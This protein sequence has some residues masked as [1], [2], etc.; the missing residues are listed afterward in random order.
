VDRLRQVLA[1]SPTPEIQIRAHLSLAEVLHERLGDEDRALASLERVLA[2]DDKNKSAL[3]RLI[4]IQIRRN[5]MDAAA[6]TAA[7]LVTVARDDA[8]RSDALRRLAELEKGRKQYDAAA[9]AYEQAVAMVGVEGTAAASFKDMLV[10]MK[11]LGEVPPWSNYVNA[12]S[13]FLERPNT[14]PEKRAEIFLEVGRV[15]GDE[16]HMGE[17][18]LAALQRGIA[19]DPANVEIRVELASRLKAAGH[20]PQ[21]LAELRKLLEVDVTRVQTWRDLVESFKGMQRQ[22]EATLAM[23]PLVA[24]GAANDL[25]RATLASRPSRFSSTMPGAF[26]DAAFRGID[27]RGAPDSAGDLL[28]AVSEALAKVHPPELERYG[29]SSRDRITSRSGNSLRM[30]ADRVAQLFGVA[31][32]DLYVHRAHS[33][34]LEVE[35]TDPPAVLVP[36]HVTGLS[37]T[38]Q[39][40]CLARPLANIARGLH[41][42]NK[43][44]PREV[45]MLLV[46]AARLADPSY[47]IGMADEDFLSGYARR[48]QKALSRRGRRNAEEAAALFLGA[49]PVDY[50]DWCEKIRRTAARAAVVVADDLPTCVTLLRR[51]EGDLAGLK[52]AALAQGMDLVADLMRFWIG[53]PSFALR[54]RLGIL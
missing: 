10:E 34:S 19:V 52:G 53:D 40:F 5:K 47:G 32:Y 48:V 11:L 18:S 43:L 1:Q 9:H 24:L 4:D 22:E 37:E 42:V 15:L 33:G 25:E 27:A 49:A 21:A 17:R 7:R 14:A 23:A 29:L 54:R 12:L 28:S 20:Y 45:E 30:L 3:E 8:E 39:V 46:A 13:G 6:A 50:T 26:D 36:A 2:L 44:P 35:L 16:M 51:T 31:E 38:E 41:A